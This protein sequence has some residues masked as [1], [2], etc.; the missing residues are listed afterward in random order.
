MFQ[1]THF[2]YWE[3][4]QIYW[5]KLVG[6]TWWHGDSLPLW[7]SNPP[8]KELGWPS[9]GHQ[10]HNFFSMQIGE[11]KYIIICYSSYIICRYRSARCLSVV[12]Q[13]DV[14]SV[15]KVS[16]WSSSLPL[17]Q[18]LSVVFSLP[19]SDILLSVLPCKYLPCVRV[20]HIFSINASRYWNAFLPSPPAPTGG[21]IL[22][23]IWVGIKVADI[24]N[25]LIWR[26]VVLVTN[27]LA[28]RL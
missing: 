28:A 27:N 9:S 16:S 4:T 7:Q 20:Q 15:C 24:G 13:W 19:H 21:H 17:R 14:E 1:Q 6:M 23:V 18:E 25:E 12:V 26:P 5:A 8:A 22:H 11:T 2:T 3:Q 10:A